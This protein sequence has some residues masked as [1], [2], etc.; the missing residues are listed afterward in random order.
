[1]FQSKKNAIATVIQPH[2][3]KKSDR[4]DICNYCYEWGK[5]KEVLVMSSYMDYHRM[6]QTALFFS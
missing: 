4:I 6:I 2:V 3:F 5:L 1:M